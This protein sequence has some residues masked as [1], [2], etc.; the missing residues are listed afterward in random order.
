M[1]LFC[2]IISFQPVPTRSTNLQPS[3]LIAA[4]LLMYVYIYIYIFVVYSFARQECTQCK[5]GR[6][7][8]YER[9][10]A[11]RPKFREHPMSTCRFLEIFRETLKFG[12]RV[13]MN[14]RRYRMCLFFIMFSAN[15]FS[16]FLR[17]KKHT[18]T[19]THRKQKMPI[20]RRLGR[21]SHNE[22]VCKQ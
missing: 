5:Y 4:P 12:T 7:I 18:H 13:S 20:R 2:D 6:G 3:D 1:P 8:I 9:V 22:H 19:Y 16:Y 15:L 10:Q 14:P 21:G 17:K 11:Y